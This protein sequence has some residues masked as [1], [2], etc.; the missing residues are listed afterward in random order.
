ME[1][2]NSI[3]YRFGRRYVAH[4]PEAIWAIK[5]IASTGVKTLSLI[6]NNIKYWLLHK[7]EDGKFAISTVSIIT[8]NLIQSKKILGFLLLTRFSSRNS[9]YYSSST[10]NL[11]ILRIS[12]PHKEESSYTM[13]SPD[14]YDTL[15]FVVAQFADNLQ[16]VEVKASA[17]DTNSNNK[18]T[19]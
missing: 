8:Q 12:T 4:L 15:G 5:Q 11:R 10:K 17:T 18:Y 9:S 6:R 19:R 3:V 14:N 13:G 7:L 16:N 1:K 2:Q